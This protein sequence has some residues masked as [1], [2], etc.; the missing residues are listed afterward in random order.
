MFHRSVDLQKT[1]AVNAADNE[2][3][4]PPLRDRFH[5]RSKLAKALFSPESWEFATQL[6]FL[7]WPQREAEAVGKGA[8]ELHP[9]VPLA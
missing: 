5:V 8:E 4:T 1:L 9:G 3:I 7:L 6:V 2:A